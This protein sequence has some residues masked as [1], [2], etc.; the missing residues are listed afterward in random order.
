MTVELGQ[1][2]L[3]LARETVERQVRS[4]DGRD[5]PLPAV[6][7]EAASGFSGA[8]VTLRCAGRLRGCIGSFSVLGSLPNTI[9][10][11][12]VSATG[13]PRFRSQPID[14]DEFDDLTVEV[15]LL[16]QPAR[17]DDP[18]ALVP[19]RHGILIRRRQ[20]TGCFLPQVATDN[21][22]DA[23]EFLSRCCEMKASLPR[24]A[25]RDPETEVHLFETVVFADT[26]P[27]SR[28]AQEG[29]E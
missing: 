13:D 21:K 7:D 16:T 8:F 19:G 15:S 26:P 22:W 25:W 6:P 20:Q 28:A 24:D 5:T 2:L 3:R 23:A 17:T 18:S 4:G 14:V 12:A 11:M 27:S 9:R 1:T 29:Q 10:E